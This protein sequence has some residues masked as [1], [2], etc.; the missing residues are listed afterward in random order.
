M[1]LD[2]DGYPDD[3][4]LAAMRAYDLVTEPLDGLLALI[5]DNWWKPDWGYRRTQR[6]LYLHTGGWSGNEDVIEALR[7]NFLFWSLCWL[8]SDR[9]GHFTFQ[10]RKSVV[11]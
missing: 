4:S 9:G 11:R 7:E 2:A 5:R 3:V 6:R 1:T 10:V 8:R